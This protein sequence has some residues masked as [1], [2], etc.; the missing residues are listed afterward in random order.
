MV[1]VQYDASKSNCRILIR[2]NRSM[3]WK[4]SL[5]FLAG[6]FAVSLSIAVGFAL[7]GAWLVFPFAGL[8][9]LVLTGGMYACARA[10]AHREIIAV[11]GQTVEV[12]KGRREP[13][14]RCCFQRAWA[15][16]HLRYPASG[17]YPSRLTIGSHGREVVIGACLTEEERQHLARELRPLLGW[18]A[19]FPGAAP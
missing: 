12:S 2:P 1:A 17:W 6:I 8:E 15:R 4:E 18:T 10:C 5:V 19:P 11:E 9:M 3:T 7:M 13:L 16:A 14:Q